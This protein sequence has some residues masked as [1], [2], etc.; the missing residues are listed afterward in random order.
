MHPFRQCF[1]F[2][3]KNLRAQFYNESTWGGGGAK[4]LE[5]E[6]SWSSINYSILSARGPAFFLKS[7]ARFVNLLGA[8]ESIP[9]LAE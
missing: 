3:Y 4:S 9:S 7:F 8:K 6:I 2:L 1:Y 5:E